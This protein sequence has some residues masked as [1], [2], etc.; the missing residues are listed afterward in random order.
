MSKSKMVVD[1][2]ATYD[3]F[4]EDKKVSDMFK[5]MPP[6]TTASM[7]QCFATVSDNYFG[8]SPTPCRPAECIPY[9]CKKQKG[10]NPMY[11]NNDK[12]IESSKINYLSDRA[13]NVYYAKMS[14]LDKTFNLDR[15]R[16]PETAEDLVKAIT[17]GNFSIKPKDEQSSYHRATD[18]IIWRNPSVVADRDGYT[19]AVKSLD[20]ALQDTKD[21]IAI[22]T[23][24][25]GLSAV[26]TLEAWTP[27]AGTVAS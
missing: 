8:N 20:A 6:A 15:P 9:D 2:I 27:A 10:N 22:G 26:K 14:P 13:S 7:S 21:M 11:V 18:N 17:D 19:A 3:K 16:V 24:A 5:M 1:L 12:H 4:R 25:E 23:P